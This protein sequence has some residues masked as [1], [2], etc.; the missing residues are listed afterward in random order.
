M[1]DKIKIFVTKNGEAIIKPV[2]KTIDDVFCML[3]KSGR[4]AV[5]IESMN[6]AIR[7]RMKGK[8]K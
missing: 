8:F 1:P 4:N 5:S 3:H 7:E 2:S 6:S